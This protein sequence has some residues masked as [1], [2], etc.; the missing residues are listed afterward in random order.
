[1]KKSMMMMKTRAAAVVSALLVGLLS[2]VPASAEAEVVEIG[3]EAAIE[4]ALTEGAEGRLLISTERDDALQFEQALANLRWGVNAGAGYSRSGELLRRREGESLDRAPA[5]DQVRGSVSASGGR[6][7][8]STSITHSISGSAPDGGE[9]SDR[10]NRSSVG[11]SGSYMVY[12]GVRGGRDSLDRE[13][14]GL[15]ADRRR[16]SRESE[17]RDL[18]LDVA[19]A[20]AALLGAEDAAD[21]LRLSVERR[22]GELARSEVLY[23]LG[24]I[25]RSELIQAEIN[26]LQAEND[27]DA[28]LH[29]RRVASERFALLTGFPRETRFA[30]QA[31]DIDPRRDV[32]L[33]AAIAEALANRSELEVHEIRRE[34]GEIDLRRLAA[35]GRPKVEVEGGISGALGWEE[36]TRSIDWNVGV[37]L[38]IPIF[39]PGRSVRRER[40]EVAGAELEL[41][42]ER[43][44]EAI[45]TE[46]GEVMQQL[47]AAERRVRVAELQLE[48]T[49]DEAGRAR[50]EYDDGV[51]S[52]PDWLA[53]RVEVSNAEIALERART[54]LRMTA[55]EFDR[56]LGR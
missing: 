6:T 21:V 12:D 17:R 28:S 35:E 49:R 42:R 25:R 27:L 39:D 3:I 2:P 50:A 20:Y 29:D 15:D 32:E 33:E 9:S 11:L 54:D 14:A 47:A 52:R 22:S 23:E 4:R 16:I 34:V 53:T 1:M 5:T 26:L 18:E 13:Q 30:L 44:V 45:R 41:E 55:I 10:T 31:A 48:R 37:Q 24:E 46:V 56:T 36:E 40:A 19:R 43:T 8:L 38:S 51:L 7:S